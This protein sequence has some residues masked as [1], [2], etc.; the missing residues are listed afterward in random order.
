V[1]AAARG[2]GI[3][4][5]IEECPAGYDTRIE[6]RGGNLSG[7]QRQKMVLARTLLKRPRVLLLDDALSSLDTQSERAIVAHLDTLSGGATCLFVARRPSTAEAAD[8]VVVLDRGG[9]VGD[10]RHEDL[11]ANN[12]V[13]ADVFQ[14]YAESRQVTG[15]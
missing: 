12:P 1:E 5:F 15:G 7:G 14:S 6:E 10:G 2:V 4:G 11:M 8:R 13:Y 3:A 9:V